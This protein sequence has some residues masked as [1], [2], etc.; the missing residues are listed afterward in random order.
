MNAKEIVEKIR[1]TF[2]ELVNQQ[3]AV[4]PDA[5]AQ[6]QPASA[7]ASAP[8]EPVKTK[9][10]LK[11]GTEIEVTEMAVGGIVTINSVPAPIG[12]YELSDGTKLVIG[13]NG[14]ITEIKTADGQPMPV[15]E[16]MNAK[17]SA[18]ETS[19]TEKFASFDNKVAEFE[20]RVVDFESRL[21]TT[22]N[23]FNDI[24]KVTESIANTP[25]G[26]PDASVKTTNNFAVR[27]QKKEKSLDI[28]FS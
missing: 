21:T 7:P 14:A 23:M 2:N 18:F 15:V 28:L 13:D 11:D 26:T 17:F 1:L 5:T 20:K 12:E 24:L 9:A 22:L 6:N 27:E 25:T 16:D 10:T 8:T 19:I 3:N 4:T